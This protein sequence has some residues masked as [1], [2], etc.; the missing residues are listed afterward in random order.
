LSLKPTHVEHKSRIIKGHDG[1]FGVE[2]PPVIV[3]DPGRAQLLE[4][5]EAV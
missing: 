4:A 5:V 2:L 1:A 3:G